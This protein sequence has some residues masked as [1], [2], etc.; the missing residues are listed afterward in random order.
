VLNDTEALG[1]LLIYSIGGHETTATALAF[2][3]LL[4]AAYPE[5]Q[6][7][8]G[9]E[10]RAVIQG[11]GSPEMLEYEKL[12]PRLKRCLAVMVCP[13]FPFLFCSCF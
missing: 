7:W 2:S 11:Q 12:F 6:N 1:N 9:E 8:I 5:W 4:L 3:I 10:I 13:E